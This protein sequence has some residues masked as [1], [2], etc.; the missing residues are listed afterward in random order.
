MREIAAFR[1]GTQPPEPALFQ[2]PCGQPEPKDLCLGLVTWLADPDNPQD[3]F[4]WYDG[5]NC[6]VTPVPAG[7]TGK[8]VDN[9]YYVKSSVDCPAGTTAGGPGCRLAVL[10][11]AGQSSVTYQ[12]MG[13]GTL[14]IISHPLEGGDHLGPIDCPDQTTFEDETYDQGNDTYVTSCKV[15]VPSGFDHSDLVLADGN[16]Y[17][18]LDAQCTIGTQAAADGELLCYLGKAPE[19]MKAFVWRNSQGSFYYDGLD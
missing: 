8:V 5:A 11:F 6:Y 16:I 18:E 15:D 10:P 1:D 4:P 14:V 17:L 3:L 12:L 2:T 9:R 13:G 7:Y 19:G